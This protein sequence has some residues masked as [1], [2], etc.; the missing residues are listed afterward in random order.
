[1]ATRSRFPIGLARLLRWA[2]NE[3]SIPEVLH[4]AGSMYEAQCP[5]KRNSSAS[6]STSCACSWCLG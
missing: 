6:F 2:E 5:R 1:M 4:M 3:K